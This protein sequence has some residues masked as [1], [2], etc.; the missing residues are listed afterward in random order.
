MYY[1]GGNNPW[2][3]FQTGGMGGMGG[4]NQY[5]MQARREVMEP[6][7]PSDKPNYPMYNQGTTW[8]NYRGGMQQPMPYRGGLGSMYGGGGMYGGYGGGMPPRPSPY[9]GGLAGRFGN[10]MFGANPYQYSQGLG[11]MN[12]N[13]QMNQ[14]PQTDLYNLMNYQQQTF[15]PT[16]PVDDDSGGAGGGAGGGG[17]GGG[18]QQYGGYGGYG[19]YSGGMGGYGGYGGGFNP[20]AMMY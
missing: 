15:N 14:F 11:S 8:Q 10:Q 16:P 17:G 4:M 6:Q 3:Q 2:Q 19:G 7:G 18:Q 9:G 12:Q 1:P 13:F 5:G 20:Y